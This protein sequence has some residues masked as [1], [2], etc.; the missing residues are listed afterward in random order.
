MSRH[1]ST[2]QGEVAD[3]RNR[4]AAVAARAGERSRRSSRGAGRLGSLRARLCERHRDPREAAGRDLQ[5][6]RARPAHRGAPGRGFDDLLERASTCR[7]LEDQDNAIVARVRELRNQMQVTVNTV[8]AARDGSPAQEQELDGHRAEARASAPPSWPRRAPAARHPGR[9]ATRRRSS[10]ATSRRSRRRSRSSSP[11]SGGVLPAGPIRPGGRRV[12]LAGQRP[13]H[14]GF[15]P[16]W[17]RMH[18]GIDIAVPSGTPIRAA[19]SGTILLAG[20]TGGYGNYTC[21]NHGG[22]LST[23]YAHQERSWSRAA[24]RC[25]GAD[26]RLLGCTGAQLRAAPALRGPGQRAGGRS[27]RLSVARNLPVSR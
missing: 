21:I 25:S 4:E 24:S 17:G 11:S 16:R 6:Q 22:G 23:C 7:T 8:T 27:R 26:P 5:V 10:R 15:G 1:S 19:K 13:G 20:S 18:E 14:L 3:L 9:S 2:L 12:H